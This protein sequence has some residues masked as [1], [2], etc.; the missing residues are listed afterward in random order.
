MAAEEKDRGGEARTPGRAP[1]RRPP[2]QPGPQSP[3]LFGPSPGEGGSSGWGAAQAAGTKSRG[4]QDRSRGAGPGGLA[5]V[6]RGMRWWRGAGEGVDE[7][8]VGAGG[9]PA[10]PDSGG[11]PFAGPLLAPFPPSLHLPAL[12]SDFSKELLTPSQ[13][14]S[15]VSRS[16]FTPAPCPLQPNPPPPSTSAPPTK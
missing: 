3:C 15:S 16:P 1:K 10:R 5:R 2:R 8:G 9:R 14:S 4:G 12:F 7:V 11:S 6:P 13:T